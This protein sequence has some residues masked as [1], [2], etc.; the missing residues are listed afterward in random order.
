MARPSLRTERLLLEPLGREHLED[1]VALDADPEVLRFVFGRALTRDEVVDTWLPR[2]TDPAYDAVGL[3][4]WVGR[5]AGGRFVGWWF[6]TPDADD[7]SRAEIGY[8]LR[9]DAWGTGLAT[10]G[11]RAV[12]EHALTTAGVRCLHA[13]VHPDNAG[14]LGVLAKLGL[15]PAGTNGDGEVVYELRA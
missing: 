11:A 2:R 3:G 1:L 9:R 7:P 14:S 12:V 10:E 15:R 8:R 13:C 4:Y 6:V 5:T